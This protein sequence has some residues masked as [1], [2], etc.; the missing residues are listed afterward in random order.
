[1]F[2]VVKNENDRGKIEFWLGRQEANDPIDKPLWLWLFFKTASW[3][4][5]Q[6]IEKNSFIQK[7]YETMGFWLSGRQSGI[8]TFEIGE[9]T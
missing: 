1:M 4:S 8:L 3:P 6:Y 2:V 7:T 5:I 9:K